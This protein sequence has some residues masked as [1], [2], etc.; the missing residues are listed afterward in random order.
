MARKID[1]MCEICIAGDPQ[2]EGASVLGG[3]GSTEKANSRR[4]L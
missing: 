3:G 1:S 2:T 4:D